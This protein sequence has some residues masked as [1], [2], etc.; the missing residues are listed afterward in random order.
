LRIVGIPDEHT[1]SG[2]QG[3]IFNYYGISPQGLV[4]TALQLLENG[5]EMK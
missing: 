3:E 1:V 5:Q 2:S 4:Q